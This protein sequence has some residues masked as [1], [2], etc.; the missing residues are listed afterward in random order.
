MSCSAFR[1]WDDEEYLVIADV[2]S[3]PERMLILTEILDGAV[4]IGGCKSQHIQLAALAQ[5]FWRR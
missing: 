2:L 4:C 1:P 5:V 3:A